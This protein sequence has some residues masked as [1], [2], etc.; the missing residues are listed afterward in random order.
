MRLG[1]LAGNRPFSRASKMLNAA[2]S[3]FRDFGCAH[4]AT[5]QL[6]AAGRVSTKRRKALP[7]EVS[8]R[9]P[10]NVFP[11]FSSG[12]FRSRSP[13]RQVGAIKR[14]SRILNVCSCKLH[15]SLQL[16]SDVSMG[17]VRLLHALKVLH[18]E[19]ALM[20]HTSV[21][22]MPATYVFPSDNRARRD[23]RIFPWKNVR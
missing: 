4:E 3:R 5:R 1:N 22:K 16:C 7:S 6:A 10:W 8:M 20:A 21:G 23:K 15:R 19:F 11:E 2:V 9:R 14:G 12:C 17:R 13:E 18:A